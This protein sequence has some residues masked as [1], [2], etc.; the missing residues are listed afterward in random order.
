MRLLTGVS[1]CQPPFIDIALR[2][3]GYRAGGGGRK[4]Q[5]SGGGLR[6]LEGEEGWGGVPVCHLCTQKTFLL[7][8]LSVILILRLKCIVLKKKIYNYC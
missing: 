5:E 3:G 1:E 6:H 7:V 8:K 2:E 4:G